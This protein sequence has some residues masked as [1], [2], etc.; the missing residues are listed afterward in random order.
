VL[1]ISFR[2]YR[3]Y[4]PGLLDGAEFEYRQTETCRKKQLTGFAE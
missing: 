4:K 3:K 1:S 2:V